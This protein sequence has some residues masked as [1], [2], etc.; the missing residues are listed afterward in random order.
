VLTI[1]N[2]SQTI[3][4]PGTAVVTKSYAVSAA[5]LQ[6][7]QCLRA[8]GTKDSSGDVVATSL[9]ITPAG[10][11]GTCTTGFGGGGG[12]GRGGGRGGGGGFPAPSG[13]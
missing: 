7:G 10:P 8:T 3:T 9:T 6:T 1:A 11:S 12:G 13:G 5:D 2:G 4:V